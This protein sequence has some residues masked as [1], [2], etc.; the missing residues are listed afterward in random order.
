MGEI[1][2]LVVILL[3][4]NT[5]YLL[6]S[7]IMWLLEDLKNYFPAHFWGPLHSPASWYSSCLPPGWMREKDIGSKKSLFLY[8]FSWKWFVM[9]SALL[10]MPKPLTVW[11]TTN[12]KILKTDGTIR[13]PYLPPEKPACRSRSNRIW[14]NGIV[15]NWERS[16]YNR[17][18]HLI[19]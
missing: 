6:S 13:P 16:T 8:C 3:R 5:G 2:M 17:L 19:M 18:E 7:A 4:F 14:N 10:T 12:W 9:T 1:K 15:Q 11:I